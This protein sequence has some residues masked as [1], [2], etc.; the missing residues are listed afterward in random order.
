MKDG[1]TRGIYILDVKYRV[2]GSWTLGWRAWWKTDASLTIWI[3]VNRHPLRASHRQNMSPSARWRCIQINDIMFVSLHVDH[4]NYSETR[5]RDGDLRRRRA[6]LIKPE[7]S[8]ASQLLRSCARSSD[9]R[10]ETWWH[11][12]QG[13]RPIW[14]ARFKR[15]QSNLIFSDWFESEMPVKLNIRFVVMGADLEGMVI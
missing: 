14:F 6:V 5:F 9:R 1:E 13:A 2:N 15:G 12:Y 7:L 8:H 4:S 3:A 10:V 11:L